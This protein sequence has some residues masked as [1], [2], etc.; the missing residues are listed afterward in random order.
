MDPAGKFV[1]FV[2]CASLARMRVVRHHR[3][4]MQ[5]WDPNAPLSWYNH[6]AT[7]ICDTA[8]AVS[9]TAVEV[10]ETV[11]KSKQEIAD[12]WGCS[13]LMQLWAMSLR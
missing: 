4:A 6:P 7:T 1:L 9:S 12:E 3:Q 13:G 2:I 10:E 11:R 5:G 8:V